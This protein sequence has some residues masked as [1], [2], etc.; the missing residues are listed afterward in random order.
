[1][2]WF[3]AETWAVLGGLLLG[4]V[5]RQVSQVGSLLS[6]I[7]FHFLF[8]ISFIEFCF[9]TNLFS[10]FSCRFIIM[11]IQLKISVMYYTTLQYEAS[12]L[13]LITFHACWPFQNKQ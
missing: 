12:I 11:L 1:V 13:Y 8:L 6:S 3:W 5:A 4:S 9:K 7:F 2:G 10:K